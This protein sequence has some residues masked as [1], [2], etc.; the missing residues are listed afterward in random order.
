MAVRAQFIILGWHLFRSSA[1]S[2]FFNNVQKAMAGMVIVLYLHSPCAH[3]SANLKL[4]SS[5]VF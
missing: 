1:N 4:D 3:H 5:F 2:K